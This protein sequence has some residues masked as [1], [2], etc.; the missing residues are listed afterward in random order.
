VGTTSY[1]AIT[2]AIAPTSKP[3]VYNN[4][5]D[6]KK[7]LENGQVDAIVVDLPTAFYI[8]ARSST[9]ARSS[10]SCRPRSAASRSSSAWSWT[11]AARSPR[12]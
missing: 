1:Q 8:T 3:K 4:N 5:D 10:V 12:A 9:T 11:R 2:S 7:A 6:A